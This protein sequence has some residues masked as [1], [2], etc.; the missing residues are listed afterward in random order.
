MNLNYTEIVQTHKMSS[1]SEG[2]KEDNVHCK[3]AVPKKTYINVLL[4]ELYEFVLL[5]YFNLDQFF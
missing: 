5:Y 2:M 1:L 3:I 4:N